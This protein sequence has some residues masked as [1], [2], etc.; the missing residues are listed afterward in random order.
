MK[1]IFHA[2]ANRPLL[3]YGTVVLI[4]GGTERVVLE[5]DGSLSTELPESHPLAAAVVLRT[6]M[7]LRVRLEDGSALWLEPVR[8]ENWSA[9]L[10]LSDGFNRQPWV[11]VRRTEVMR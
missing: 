7:T 3:A 5:T 2:Y 6:R 9:S 4:T 8:D 1:G 10:R 11:V